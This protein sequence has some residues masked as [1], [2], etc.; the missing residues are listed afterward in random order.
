MQIRCDDQGTCMNRTEKTSAKQQSG[1][2]VRHFALNPKRTSERRRC[3]FCQ[4][5]QL[6][7]PSHLSSWGVSLY[8]SSS[9]PKDRD[10]ASQTIERAEYPISTTEYFQVSNVRLLV[11]SSIL[12]APMSWQLRSAPVTEQA[13]SGHSPRLEGCGSFRRP[14]RSKLGEIWKRRRHGGL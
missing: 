7:I 11:L 5:D 3:K 4:L 10:E 12:S 14:E 1:S 2:R 6:N 8:Q 9:S 13:Q